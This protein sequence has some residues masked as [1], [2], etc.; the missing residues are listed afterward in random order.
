[1][2]ILIPA[3]PCNFHDRR[4]KVKEECYWYDEERDM[5][6]SVPYCKKKG[7]Y[8]LDNCEEC[9]DYIDRRKKLKI[10]VEYADKE[11]DNTPTI[12]EAEDE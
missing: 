9:R 4:K 12:I 8:P 5:G 6:A 3:Y 2:S 10:T 11:E 7:T 1:M